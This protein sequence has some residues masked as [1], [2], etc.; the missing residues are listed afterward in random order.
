MT[1]TTVLTLQSVGFGT[2]N[3]LTLICHSFFGDGKQN[4]GNPNPKRG[5]YKVLLLGLNDLNPPRLE[6]LN[7]AQ[8]GS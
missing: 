8:N 4:H 5:I 3:L 7:L 6:S 2:K 1:R